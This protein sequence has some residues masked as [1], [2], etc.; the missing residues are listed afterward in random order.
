M[1]VDAGVD[2]DKAA[3]DDES[4]PLVFQDQ[5]NINSGPVEEAIY[6]LYIFT[7]VIMCWII[8]SKYV[9]KVIV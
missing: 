5:K 9:I 6:M 2:L 8:S 3:K 7:N 1:D 4:V